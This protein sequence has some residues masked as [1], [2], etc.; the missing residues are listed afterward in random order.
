K[1]DEDLNNN[2][3][4]DAVY[5]TTDKPLYQP[6]QTFNL[7]ALEFDPSNTVV[8]GNELEFTIE[9]EDDTVVY[10]Q[11]VKT[12]DFGIASIT[13]PI[14]D[15]SKLGQ[16]TV[17]VEGDRD[18]RQD[19][20]TFKVSRY[21]LPNFAVKASP[22]KSYYLTNDQTANITVSAD[23]LFGRP[24]PDGKVRVV[25]ESERHW[26]YKQQKYDV[27]E[28][29]TVEGVADATGK[30]V[31]KLDLTD[32]AE[33]LNDSEWK[34]YKDISFAAYVTDPL[35]NRTEQ[36]RFDIRLTKKPIHIYLAYHDDRRTDLPLAVYVSTFYADGTPAICSV[37][38][39]DE[40]GNVAH[41]TTNKLGASKVSLHLPRDLSGSQYKIR[42]NARDK[43]GLDGTYE[44]SLYLSDSDAVEITTDKTIYKP[45]EMI[46]ADVISNRQ[47]DLI[48]IDIAKDWMPVDRHIVRLHNGKAH[49]S[50][51]YRPEFK[52]DLAI[53]A[54]GDRDSGRYSYGMH[55]SHGII[56]PE[57]Q[58]L[59]LDAKFS[60][61]EYHPAENALLR[62]SVR[63]GSR[64]P[65]E[66]AI[67]LS[68]FDKAIEERARTDSDFGG[69]FGRFYNLMGYSRSYGGLTVK[70]LN[71][72][73]LS[74]PISDDM[75]LAAEMILADEWYYPTIY[76]SGEN[77]K[78][79]GELY[80]PALKLQLKPLDAALKAADQRDHVH[81]TDPASL[82]SILKARGIDFGSLRD[83][84]GGSYFAKFSIDRTF[85]VM[86]IKSAGPDKKVGTSDDFELLSE[87][88]SYFAQ[89]EI[90]IQA[91]A[92]LY[93][94]H[95]GGYIRDLPTL[96]AELR[97]RGFDLGKLK[98]RWGHDYRIKFGVLGRS[99]SITLTSDG[100]NGVYE[101]TGWP[102]D[103]FV[104][105]R[106]FID[107][108]SPDE[109]AINQALDVVVNKGH[110]AFPRTEDDFKAT[111]A[112]V[113]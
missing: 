92:E 12:S 49:V 56:F 10:R 89:T 36:R 13:W 16:Y 80:A 8:T 57:Q 42:I 54:Y 97:S 100:P 83:P 33:D 38:I 103:D 46:E 47:D 84:W 17:R 60:K 1:I 3:A 79:A 81:P 15:N 90:T 18:L 50:I 53:A 77:E 75:Q 93:H 109:L 35:T 108:F 87:S 72:I 98:D 63:D 88:F 112:S 40:R 6:G 67:G 58:N 32:D 107:Y 113:G 102:S 19:E 29:Q 39:D 65:I 24:V 41:V 86:V 48:Y 99:Y 25:E 31:A 4:A 52:G 44:D 23:Y 9:D 68:I 43:K 34:R 96:G 104:A 55:D 21:D 82:S 30:F 110:K 14:P 37:D 66:S 61:D 111:L 85:D 2:L 73:D 22:D 45:G 101:P 70:D 27:D 106:S 51:P 5:M 59:I 94:E 78:D 69:Y 20:I 95:T 76:H 71:D 62:F 105:G 91:V 11:K 7:R 28:G 74:Q 64:Q 26:N